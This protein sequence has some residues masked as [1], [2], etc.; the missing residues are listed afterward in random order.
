MIFVEETCCHVGCNVVWQ[1]TQGQYN[2]LQKT[3]AT[4]FCPNGHAQSYKGDTLAQQYA[5]IAADRLETIGMLRKQL[6]EANKPKHK[7]K[8]NKK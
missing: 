1:I 2:Q 4:F 3:K 5:K 8:I 6:E 7:R